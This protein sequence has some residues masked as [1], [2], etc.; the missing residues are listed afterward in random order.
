[1]CTQSLAPQPPQYHNPGSAPDYMVDI[2]QNM[3]DF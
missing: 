1:M 3:K 2:E